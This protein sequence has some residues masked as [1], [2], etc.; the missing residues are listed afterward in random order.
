MHTGMES[1]YTSGILTGSTRSGYLVCTCTYWYILSIYLYMTGIMVHRSTH[2]LVPSMYQNNDIDFWQILG[3]NFSV[4]AP[5]HACHAHSATHSIFSHNPH[6][7]TQNS[8]LRNI[9]V[10]MVHNSMYWYLLGYNHILVPHT[11]YHFP[12]AK[13]KKMSIHIVSWK[14]C[15]VDQYIPVCTRYVQVHTHTDHTHTS[16][17]IRHYHPCGLH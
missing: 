3:H 1:I 10:N 6:D 12:Q 11:Q 2:W 17:P 7:W 15:L 16:F 13:V 14:F 5:Q 8:I 4:G 9:L